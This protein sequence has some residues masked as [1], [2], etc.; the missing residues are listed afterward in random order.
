[1]L[2]EKY[3]RLLLCA[4]VIACILFITPR[5]LKK[6]ALNDGG[7]S[8][9]KTEEMMLQMNK[10]MVEL[11]KMKTGANQASNDGTLSAANSDTLDKAIVGH[12]AHALQEP[13]LRLRIRRNLVL[14]CNE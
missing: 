12:L 13:R 7:Q 11:V 1:M 2:G 9:S 6:D 4:V 14:G 3:Q 8:A 10:L 5:L